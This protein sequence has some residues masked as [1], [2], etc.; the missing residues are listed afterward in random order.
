MADTQR[1]RAALIALLAD[2]NMFDHLHFND[3]YGDWDDDMMVGSVHLWETLEALY[4]ADRVGYDS[5]YN[6]DI[7]PYRVEP[8]VA[9]KQSI[10]N[11]KS[12]RALLDD[13]TLCSRIEDAQSN[14]DQSAAVGDIQELLRGLLRK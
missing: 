11:I 12:L 9:T 13:T 1:T 5:W 6:L 3:N 14:P 7:Y 2:N 4:W 8:A 10:E